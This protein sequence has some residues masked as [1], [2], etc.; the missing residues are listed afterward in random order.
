M[1]LRLLNHYLLTLRRFLFRMPAIIAGLLVLILA[2]FFFFLMITEFRPVRRSSLA[3]KGEGKPFDSCQQEFTI[4]TWN[5]GYAGLGAG[6]DFFFDGGKSVRAGK[7]QT[8]QYLGA[9]EKFIS[10]NDSV[11]FI[12]LQEVDVCSKRSWYINEYERISELLPGFSNTF[13][14]NYNCRHIPMPL[15]EPMGSVL[16]GIV[17]FSQIKPY[18]ASVQYFD[19]MFDWPLRMVLLKRCFTTLRYRLSDGKD[20]VLINTHNSAYDSIGTLRKRELFILDSVMQKEFHKGNYIIAGGDWNNNPR[21][22]KPSTVLTGDIVTTVEPPIERG[23]FPGWQFVFD[24]LFPTNRNLNI[25]Y[26]KGKTSSTI[27]DF[28]I[29]SPNVEVKMIKTI[30]MGFRFSDHEPVMMKIKIVTR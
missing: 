11:D 12:L 29:V 14:A 17:S 30:R 18:A 27:I 13:A 5:I 2:G 26:T 9:I 8:E 20:L 3:V 7:M 10:A 24:S 28:F 23:F 19:A 16:A 1:Y 22:F 25:P 4:L 15:T 6:A 21:G